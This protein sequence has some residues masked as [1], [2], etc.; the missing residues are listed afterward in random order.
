MLSFLYPAAA[1]R[2][3]INHARAV[4]RKFIAPPP[5]LLTKRSYSSSN[6]PYGLPTNEDVP[7][8]PSPTVEIDQ[9]SDTDP[10]SAW[11]YLLGTPSPE[12]E[13]LTYK[14]KKKGAGTVYST[15]HDEPS[16]K[17]PTD[18]RRTFYPNR[19]HNRLG[20]HHFPSHF[21]EIPDD[22]SMN[23]LVATPRGNMTERE[24]V[25]FDMIFDKLLQ[26]QGTAA[27]QR[28]LEHQRPS[29]MISA[30]FESAVG[31]QKSGDEVSFGPE[32][33][34]EIADKGSMQ[35]VLKR[36]N[37]PASLRLAAAGAMGLSRKAVGL[38]DDENSEERVKEYTKLKE[39]LDLCGN[40][41]EILEF[42]D[43]EVFT[44]AG[45]GVFAASGGEEEAVTGNAAV[46]TSNYPKLLRDVIRVFRT[47]YQ[48]FSAC[49]SVFENIKQ[50]GPESYIIGCS[51]AVYNEM[52]LVRWKGYRDIGAVVD[53]LDEM[54]LNGV[55]GNAETA[56]IV[57]DVL[58]DVR[59]FESN[60]FL[61]GTVMMWSN[62]NVLDGKEKLKEIMGM[63]VREGDAR[64]LREEIGV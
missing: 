15:A 31:P 19:N 58:N 54:R 44:M 10:S 6:N 35:A 42:L 2:H 7:E 11:G 16:H 48:D 64:G 9:S 32:R 49:I 51:V 14:P 56:G 27:P 34:D 29:P 26:K 5:V 55:E 45:G 13:L 18:N 53:L 30:L 38:E 22:P 52:L 60:A 28:K 8:K 25:I 43:E 36:G 40:D 61:P 57:A 23:A 62:E 47:E 4:S 24:K 20:R 12:D 41:L 33:R 50:L 3:I 46:P 39:K 17:E 37:F 1:R 63:L 59:V 21:N